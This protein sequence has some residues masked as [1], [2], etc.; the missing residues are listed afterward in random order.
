MLTGDNGSSNSAREFD[1]AASR[2]IVPNK[3]AAAALK[4]A[5]YP[6]CLWVAEVCPKSDRG[7]ASRT[8]SLVV[9]R[10][11]ELMLPH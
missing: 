9:L 6:L 4:D 5:D 8:A 1:L 11:L 2:L 7:E 3:L 10:A